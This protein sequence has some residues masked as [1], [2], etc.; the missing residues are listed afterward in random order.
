MSFPKEAEKLQQ[1]LVMFPF[2]VTNIQYMR[3]SW[4]SLCVIKLTWCHLDLTNVV[5]IIIF[6]HTPTPA[7]TSPPCH[8]SLPVLILFRPL[9]FCFPFFPSAHGSVF[10]RF[11]L[12]SN[13]FPLLSRC[14]SIPSTF[15]QLPLPLHSLP[16][17]TSL[18]FS[19]TI[20]FSPFPQK[21]KCT[22]NIMLL[23][24]VDVDLVSQFNR[25]CCFFLG[26]IPLDP[27]LAQSLEDGQAFIDLFPNSPTLDAVNE[28][29]SKL[30]ATES[31]ANQ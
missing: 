25:L 8:L 9:P 17:S 7:V 1:K 18:S 6:S 5:G 14:V 19:S 13:P 10:P 20:Y 15:F 22:V 12:D 16:V 21:L 29:T 2:Q 11:P 31:N 30:L 27:S 28:I 26:C 4:I 24:T 23:F 3:L